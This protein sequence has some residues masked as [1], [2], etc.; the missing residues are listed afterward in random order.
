MNMNDGR[1]SCRFHFVDVFAVEPLTGKP[2]AVVEDAND[3]TVDQ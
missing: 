3:L 2:L 1:R